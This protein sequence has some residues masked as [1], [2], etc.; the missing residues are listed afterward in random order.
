MCVRCI[1]V[2]VWRA[3]TSYD[4]CEGHEHVTTHVWKSRDNFREL[5]LVFHYVGRGDCTRV[6][7]LDSRSLSLLSHL[8]GPKT[9]LK[10]FP[11][12]SFWC[13]VNQ[14]SPKTYPS[15]SPG[16][17][18][19]LLLHTFTPVSPDTRNSVLMLL[20]KQGLVIRPRINSFRNL[21]PSQ[22][23]W[24]SVAVTDKATSSGND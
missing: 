21:L 18:S 14:V 1:C 22:S 3:W 4:M 13:L 7:G 17:S 10:C 19:S 20:E 11:H 9:N 2:C 23:I 8:T 5:V 15:H 12:G 16:I 6:A 24:A